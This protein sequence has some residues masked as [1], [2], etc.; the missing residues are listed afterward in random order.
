MRRGKTRTLGLMSRVA[1]SRMFVASLAS[2]AA[3]FL[4]PIVGMFIDWANGPYVS[5]D[6]S[7]DNA[8]IRAAGLFMVLSPAIFLAVAVATFAIALFLQRLKLL[9]P[10]VLTI[11]V[12]LLGVTLALIM[13]LDRP[14]GWEDRLYYFLGFLA[15]IV[16]TLGISSFVWWK[17]AM[18]PNN[19]VE[20]DG[21]EAARPSP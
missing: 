17:V 11:M 21:P 19:T 14:F 2:T 10:R 7:P 8:P 3:F 18:R 5:P 12:A 13:V 1:T 15:L 9:R 16:A 20:R 6:G 4:V